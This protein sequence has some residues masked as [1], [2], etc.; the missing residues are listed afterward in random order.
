MID[1]FVDASDFACVEERAVPFFLSDDDLIQAPPEVPE[2]LIYTFEADRD[3]LIGYDEK[4][5]IHHFFVCAKAPVD[6]FV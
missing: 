6:R 3:L 1:S 2:C 4:M 5:D